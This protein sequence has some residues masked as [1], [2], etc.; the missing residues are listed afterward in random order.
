MAVL[1]S[2]SERVRRTRVFTRDGGAM[3]W[4]VGARFDVPFAFVVTCIL[5][6]YFNRR[7]DGELS[8]KPPLFSP[9]S[10]GQVATERKTATPQAASLP[11]TRCLTKFRRTAPFSGETRTA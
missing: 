7:A 4:P 5:Q 6:P 10:H 8:P 11:P 3:G 1:K 2:W 9:A